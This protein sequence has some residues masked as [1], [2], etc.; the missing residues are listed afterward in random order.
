MNNYLAKSNPRETI[1]VHTDKLLTNYELLK[2]LYPN[3]LPNWDILKYACIY[4][5]LGKMNLKFQSKIEGRKKYPDEIAHNFLSLA[6]LNT[7]ELK[8]K[9][10]DD[11]I[12]LLAQAVAYHHDRGDYDADNYE[13]EIE[14]IKKESKNFQY[15]KVTITRIKKIS[16]KYF[17]NNRIY[18]DE[19]EFLDY[20]M[21]KGLLNRLDYAA[22]ADIPVEIQNDFLLNGLENFRIKNKFKWK[23][24]Q[25]FMKENQNNNIIAVAQTGMGKTEAGLLWIGDNKG[26]FTLPL[27]TAIN[28]IYKRIT[29]NI[30]TVKNRQSV[31]L[32]HSD[33]YTKYLENREEYMDVEDYFIKT[34]Q[35]TLPLTICTLDQIFDVVFRYRDFEP[36]LATL[37]YSKVV[38]DE[39]QM[40]S[41]DLLAYLILGLLYIT[42]IGGKFAILTATLPEIIIDLLKKERIQF[43]K[44]DKAFVNNMIRHSLKVENKVIN[45]DMIAENYEDN[46]ILVICNTVK[47]AQEIYEKL[48]KNEELTKKCKNINLFHGKFIKEDRKEK[49]AEIVVMGKL[50]SNQKGIWVATQVIEASL[51]IDFDLL[52]TELSDLNGLFQRM[53]RCYRKREFDKEGYNCYVFNGGE[54]QCS[55]VGRVIDE[56]IFELSKDALKN[57]N[58][59]I[60]EVEKLELINSVYTTEKLKNSKYYTEVLDNIKYVKSINE[61]ELDKAEVRKRFRNIDSITVIPKSVYE[62]NKEVIQEKICILGKKSKIPE[63]RKTLREEKILAL[64]KIKNFMVSIHYNE[65]KD[66]VIDKININKYETLNILDCEYSKEKGVTFLKKTQDKK[67]GSDKNPFD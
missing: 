22:S 61:Y 42:E 41:S 26:F 3:L 23:E 28:E 50:E 8:E 54:K 19:K 35:M 32:L 27:K 24:L 2:N 18:G 52:F 38:I 57:Q 1:Q 46:K 66:R 40:Y 47:K 67:R 58:G 49:E 6:F 29:E 39:I 33:T 17:S 43:I 12:K 44:P 48:I 63:E 65:G 64:E 14:L 4:H 7:K 13:E 59:K 36:K 34:K 20:V 31:G 5:D 10:S 25:M 37:S 55:G 11:E 60:T 15:D 62:N 56:K 21:V 9:F 16:V 51:D 53:G 30:I 45:A